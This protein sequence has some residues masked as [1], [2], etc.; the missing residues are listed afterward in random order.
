MQ[1]S[2][3]TLQNSPVNFSSFSL[4]FILILH[5][6]ERNVTALKAIDIMITAYRQRNNPPSLLLMLGNVTGDL[7]R[8]CIRT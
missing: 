3:F 6:Y 8:F 4:N 1:S 7:F 5:F 2:F